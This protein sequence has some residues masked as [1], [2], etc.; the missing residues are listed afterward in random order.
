ME[1]SG[2]GTAGTSWPNWRVVPPFQIS[3]IVHLNTTSADLKSKESVAR[4]VTLS[5]PLGQAM[6][7]LPESTNTINVSADVNAWFNQANNISIAA[8]PVCMTP[9]ELAMKI[10][11]NY[12]G[13]FTVTNVVNN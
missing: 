1:C 7:F 8:N 13:M 4:R 9:G 11:D 6:D 12:S 10:A 2:P 3:L 5:F